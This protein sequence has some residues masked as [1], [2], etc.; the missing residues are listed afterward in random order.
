[1]ERVMSESNPLFEYEPE[2]GLHQKA[3][4]QVVLAK[5]G[6]RYVFRYVPG[7]EPQ[8]FEDLV[9]MADDPNCDLDWFDAAVLAHQMGQQISQQLS[10]VLRSK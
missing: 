5:S 10:T 6:Q 3:A 2:G 7:E 1:M 9:K 4:R 8:I